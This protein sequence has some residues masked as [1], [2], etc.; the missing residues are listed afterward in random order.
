[1]LIF[2]DHIGE[3]IQIYVGETKEKGYV[4]LP[5]AIKLMEDEEG[6]VEVH[7][8][9]MWFYLIHALYITLPCGFIKN[10]WEYIKLE[11]KKNRSNKMIVMGVEH[12]IIFHN[13]FAYYEQDMAKSIIFF[14]YYNNVYQGW[15]ERW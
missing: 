8:L 10:C 12:V 5:C 14:D 4:I 2:G 3:S 7:E 1:L 11:K 15:H 6:K 13:L 9:N